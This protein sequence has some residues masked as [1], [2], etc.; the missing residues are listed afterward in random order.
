MS[1]L[2]KPR[3]RI[4]AVVRPAPM[5]ALDLA[6]TTLGSQSKLAQAVGLKSAMAISQ[7]RK[8]GIPA[9]HC[10]TIERV[11]D[12]RVTIHEL[13]PDIFGPAPASQQVT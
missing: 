7:W 5:N 12:R 9:R 1:A 10:L 3:I 4:M 8:R 13:R 11:T 2:V 6:I